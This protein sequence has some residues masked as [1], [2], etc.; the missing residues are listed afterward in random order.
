[1]VGGPLDGY[2]GRLLTIRGS[3]TRRLLVDLPGFFSVGVEIEAEWI[4]VL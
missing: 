4:C 1:M 3:K 2:E